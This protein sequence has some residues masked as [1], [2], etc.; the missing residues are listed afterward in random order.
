MD[1]RP[2]NVSVRCFSIGLVLALI[3]ACGETA[4]EVRPAAA[5]VEVAALLTP[6]SA[7][8]VI[9]DVRTPEEFAAGHIPGAVNINID[10]ED[11]AGAVAALD[12]DKTYVVHCA[13]NVPQGR[14]ER[15][16]GI[17]Q[18]LGFANLQNMVGGIGAWT[19]AGGALTKP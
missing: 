11:F 12:R 7:S 16:L 9:L 14:S 1:G 13:A 15:A 5:D 19:E 3:G 17:M 18:E 10:G 6:S 8:S 4:T 2:I